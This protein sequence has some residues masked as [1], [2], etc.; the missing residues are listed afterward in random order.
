MPLDPGALK[1][2][3]VVES[4]DGAPLVQYGDG[5]AL[6]GSPLGPDDGNADEDIDGEDLEGVPLE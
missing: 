6:D 1:Q 5:D 3:P 2:Q 4:L